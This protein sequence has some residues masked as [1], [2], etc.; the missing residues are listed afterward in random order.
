MTGFYVF[1]IVKQFFD[2]FHIFS[3]FIQIL[4]LFC[5]YMLFFVKL[6]IFTSFYQTF[7]LQNS[8]YF[9]N[10]PRKRPLR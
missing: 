5:R 7:L 2:F 3:F 9:G 1:S 8:L 6:I 4:L 10:E